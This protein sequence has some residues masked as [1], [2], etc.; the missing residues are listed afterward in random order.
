MAL[1]LVALPLIQPSL[2]SVS[3]SSRG[4]EAEGAAEGGSRYP[5]WHHR[6]LAGQESPEAECSSEQQVL[7]TGDHP[8]DPSR[9]GSHRRA[10]IAEGAGDQR[11]QHPASAREGH[12]CGSSPACP[13]QGCVHRCP[14]VPG[15]TLGEQAPAEG[16]P[17]LSAECTDTPARTEPVLCW[18]INARGSVAG[19]C[20]HLL[21]APPS[22]ACQGG[23]NWLLLTESIRIRAPAVSSLT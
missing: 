22:P 6:G 2:I 10:G 14:Q 5:S 8:G 1:S 23:W 7:G 19:A 21:T 12:V 20:F 4:E 9:E 17:S 13:C 3:L 15:D 16:C 18:V 11:S